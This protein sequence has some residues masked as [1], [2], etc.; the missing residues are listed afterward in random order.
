MAKASAASTYEILTVKKEGRPEIDITGTSN[1]PQTVTFDYY[2]SLFSPS[3]TS[4]ISL[5]DNGSSVPYDKKFDSQERMGTLSSALPLSGDVSFSFKIKTKYGYL[6]YTKKP[7]LFD[8]IANPGSESNREAVIINLV[9]ETFKYNEEASVHKKYTGNIGD[10]VSSI[11]NNYLKTDKIKVDKTQNSY[12][13]VGNG[14]TP[15]EVI[16]DLSRKSVPG[17]GNPGYFFYETREGLNFR[18]IDELIKQTPVEK[19]N[20][21]DVL[22]SNQDNDAND[23]KILFKTDVKKGDL[24]NL[25]KSGGIFSKSILWNPLNF[26]YEEISEDV[27]KKLFTSLGKDAVL[28]TINDSTRTTFHIKDIGTLSRKLREEDPNNDPKFWQSTSTMRYNL[29]FNQIIQI[30]VP[31]NVKLKAGDTIIC[32]FEP[33]TTSKKV[34]GTDPTMSGKYLIVNLCHHFDPLRSYTSLT[35]VSDSYGLYTNKNK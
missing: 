13:F 11:T 6:D 30:Q 17:K 18:S 10:V 24:T 19:Y 4:V 5:V 14:R 32:D 8:K 23:F 7:L 2:E 26:Q 25:L 16:C 21:T 12:S 33:V 15:F 22:K 27:S 35:L 31:C 3:V 1:G 29:L 28:P 9:S 34:Q 20:R